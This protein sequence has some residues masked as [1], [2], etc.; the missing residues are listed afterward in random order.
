MLR[1]MSTIIGVGSGKQEHYEKSIPNKQKMGVP[2]Y[3]MLNMNY[4][5]SLYPSSTA[6]STTAA[7]EQL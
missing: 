7:S 5:L 1:G 3:Q 2:Q 4:S 6:K